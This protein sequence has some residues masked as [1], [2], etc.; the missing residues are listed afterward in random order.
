VPVVATALALLFFGE[1]P[2][3]PAAAGGV[4]ILAGVYVTI[5]AQ[6]QARRAEVV[7]LE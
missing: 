1:V 4:V 5:S 2:S 7:A 6:A 3:W